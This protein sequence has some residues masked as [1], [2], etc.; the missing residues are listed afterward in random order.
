MQVIQSF[1]RDLSAFETKRSQLEKS[2]KLRKPRVRNGRVSEIKTSEV[3]VSSQV[4]KPGIG[5]AGV[6]EVQRFECRQSCK[7]RSDS[8]PTLV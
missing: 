6:F 8:S 3:R 7:C 4:D 5:D 1:V 2:F